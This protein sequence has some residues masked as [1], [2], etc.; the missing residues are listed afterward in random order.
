MTTDVPSPMTLEKDIVSP[1]MLVTV[2]SR[3]G[4]A[5][6]SVAG[7][8]S[9]GI[10]HGVVLAA[11]ASGVLCLLYLC[12]LRAGG[13]VLVVVSVKALVMGDRKSVV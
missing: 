4:F 12:K 10:S 9:V 7:G 8:M 6:S 13:V 5:F 2:A 1:L 3:S 11:E